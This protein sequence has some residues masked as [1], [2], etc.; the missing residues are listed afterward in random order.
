MKDIVFVVT[1]L[2]MSLSVG[3]VK[4]QSSKSA[5][6]KKEFAKYWL[7][8]SESPDYKVS[9]LGDTLEF[10]AP[11]GMTVWRK[12][13]LT[14]DVVIEYDACIVN[15]GKE[16]DRT[17]DLN[18]F[19][20]ASDPKAKDVF[21]RLSWRG[22]VFLKTY[23][24]Q[25]YYMG[26]GGNYNGTTRFRRYDGNDLAVD[27]A[28][29]RPGIL[30]EYTDSA[31]MIKPNHWYHIKI[32]QKD[33]RVQYFIDG[34]RLVNYLDPHPLTEGWFGF[35]TTWSRM[36]VTN[37]KVTKQQQMSS[38]PLQWIGEKPKVDMPVSFGVPFTQGEMTD[39]ER[40]AVMTSDGR[41]LN[42]D[43]DVMAKWPDGSVKWLGVSTVVSPCDSLYAMKVKGERTSASSVETL[44]ECIT[45][46]KLQVYISEGGR[47]IIDSLYYEGRLIARNIDLFCSVQNAA[48]RPTQYNDYNSKINNVEVRQGAVK[49]VV[50]IEGEHL[51][52]FVVRLYLYKDTEQVKLVHTLLYTADF[53]KQFV[54]SLGLRASVPMTSMLYNRHVAFT[55]DGG[56]VWSE[57]IQPLVGRIPLGGNMQKRQMKGELIPDSSTF[58]G[59]EKM[60]LREWASWGDFRL[61]QA[62]P[63]GFTLRK[64]TSPG[65]TWVGT[66]AGRRA[67]G[68]AYVGSPEGGL[69]M[70]AK[71][72]WQSSPASFEITGARG[73]EAQMIYYMWSPDGEVMDLRHYDSVAHGLIS[74][75]E[76]VQEG[77]STPYGIART[78]TITLVPGVIYQ[79][80]EALNE[81]AREFTKINQL[82]CNPSYL[83]AK[84]AFGVWS[85]PDTMSSE[86]AEIERVL[87][88]EIE[89]YKRAVEK[90]KWY[91][92]WNY[93]DFMHSYDHVRGEWMYDVGGYAWD[94]TELA[95]NM[96]L[97]Y[98]FLRTG[99]ADIW[100]LA[101][102][103]SRHT[104]EVDV[105]H[106][107]PHA[108]LGS[109]HNVSHWGCGA[110]ESRISQ[111]AWNRFYYYLTCDDRSGDLMREVR[112]AEQKLYTLDPM[113][114]A[115]PREKYPCSAP[116]RLRVGPDW[117]AYAGNWFSEWERTGNVNY[118]NKITAGMKSIASLRHGLFTGNKALGYDPATGIVSFDGDT[119]MQ[120]TNHLLAIMGGFEI[121][122]EIM[123]SVDVPEWD[124]AWN[125]HASLY[126][127]KAMQISKNRFRVS[128][129]EGLAAWKQRNPKRAEEAWKTL[130]RYTPRFAD[131]D[132][133]FTNDAATWGLDAIYLMEV[134]GDSK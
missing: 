12:E 44:P 124:K 42:V 87:D 40:L 48:E 122:T 37:F 78:S 113:R 75:Y 73:D 34:E 14:S 63:N 49:T 129:L 54:N 11:K 86:N 32:M 116:T 128:R 81:C 5:L 25:L 57:P 130:M 65:H 51:M 112:D 9:F 107:G 36:R 60:F 127:E 85:M 99:R 59:R 98:S 117:L 58:V 67:D 7:I 104:G 43:N 2:L 21:E 119:A 101:E 83:H 30:K 47:N 118:L 23:S 95:T 114:L 13:K 15:E 64:R 4:A 126:K 84:R 68:V 10:V 131:T 93:G 105:Y 19:W 123:M 26:Y 35:R 6:N 134:I 28:E 20:L 18:C 103:M 52:P 111:S 109:R 8:E 22:G 27:S 100:I 70:V 3:I 55:Y 29:L 46:G 120:N 31:H 62:G 1:T 53:E 115:E 92:Y 108:M 76:D 82:V 45:T 91:G 38:I 121:M 133:H 33:G 39:K 97:W 17:S 106:L 71:D 132:P 72:F 102:A 66:H 90:H 61:T 74:S 77:F 94:N 16:C 79:G 50:K 125:S 80:K 88:A 69:M 41:K 89:Y 110:K 56:E 24:M 96:W